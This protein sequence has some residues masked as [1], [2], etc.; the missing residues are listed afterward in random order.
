MEKIVVGKYRFLFLALGLLLIDQLS[1]VFI[2]LSQPSFSNQLFQITLTFNTG[3][4]FSF[5][6]SA[7]WSNIFFIIL[8]VL[9][10]AGMIYLFHEYPKLRL[11]LSFLLAGAVG[12]LIDRIRLGAVV[13]FIDFRFWPIF[14]FADMFILTGIILA[15]I[16]LLK[17][18]ELTSE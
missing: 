2:L 4:L 16:V 9:L 5:L 10:V 1:K 15:F 3:A 18:E 11:S 14:N 12:N 7:S 13:D 17:H 8:S 6:S